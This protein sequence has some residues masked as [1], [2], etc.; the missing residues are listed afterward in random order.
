MSAEAKTAAEALLTDSLA[1][2]KD[3]VLVRAL[4]GNTKAKDASK[5]E[6]TTSSRSR[7]APLP[8]CLLTLR[9][10]HSAVRRG[11]SQRE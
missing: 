3:P 5:D 10:D 8:A 1:A 11:A 4:C 6:A 2:D 9:L 7:Q